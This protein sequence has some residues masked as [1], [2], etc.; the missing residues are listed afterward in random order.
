MKLKISLFLLFLSGCSQSVTLTD[1]MQPTLNRG[2]ITANKL[3]YIN[4]NPQRGDIVA[5]LPSPSLKKLEYHNPYISRIVGM[6]GE[7]IAIISG[8]VFINDA[9]F[10]EN[11]LPPNT[12]TTTDVCQSGSTSIYLQTPQTI[13]P[14]SYLLLGDN[15][16]SSY[17]GRCWG[18]IPRSLIVGKVN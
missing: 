17:D 10:P 14:D 11:Y 8:K 3:A 4:S 15:R 1:S 16:N 6:P 12:Q 7:K 5:Y 9:P 18:V 2:K 13:P